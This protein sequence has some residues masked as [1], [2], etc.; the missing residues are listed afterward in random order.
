MVAVE[1]LAIAMLLF[2]QYNIRLESID[3]CAS[4]IPTMCAKYP[5]FELRA[6]PGQRAGADIAKGHAAFFIL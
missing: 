6:R 1:D 4:S 2:Y 3:I 5:P